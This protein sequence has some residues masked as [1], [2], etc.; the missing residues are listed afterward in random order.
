MVQIELLKNHPE[1]IKRLVDIWCDVLGKVWLPDFNIEK[2]IKNFENHLNS[3][4]LPLTYIAFHE[5]LPVGMASLRVNDGIRPDLS[6]WLGSLVVD[7]AFQKR[8]IGEFLINAIKEKAKIMGFSKLYLFAFD[9]TIPD[10]YEKL[11][12]KKIGIDQFKKHPVTV[13]EISI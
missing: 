11:G 10:W 5:Q 6:P 12:W 2:V 3:E 7:P 1:H 9:P 13:M 8:G 4:N